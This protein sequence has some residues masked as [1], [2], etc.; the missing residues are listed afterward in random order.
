MVE[1]GIVMKPDPDDISIYEFFRKEHGWTPSMVDAQ[2]S[3]LIE[4]FL[5][6]EDHREQMRKAKS[7]G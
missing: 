7:L 5:I 6:I 1:R 3:V 4:K 2:D